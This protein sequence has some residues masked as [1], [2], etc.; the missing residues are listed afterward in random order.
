MK[1]LFI[2][3]TC[4]RFV[5]HWL[6]FKQ[7]KNHEIIADDLAR[8]IAQF[9]L[10]K[11]MVNPNKKDISFYRFC[12]LLSFYKMVRNIFYARVKTHSKFAVKVMSLFA[13]PQS[14]LDISSSASIGGGLIVQHG[15]A[16]IIDPRSMGQNCW[17]NQGVT[18]GYTNDTDC[19]T[20]GNNV[21]IGAG[22][23]VLGNVTVG[24]NVVIGANCVVV[25]D[26]PS[27]STV[28]GV[29]ARIVKMN[30]VKVDIKL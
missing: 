1:R 13:F 23:K 2:Y 3:L 19:P 9:V 8:N 30:G 29:P 16:T 18:I 22:A 7:A 15:Y 12:Y 27:N 14:F 17:V 25:K 4:F 21:V 6:Y 11:G 28:V 20:I 26:I 10:R 24:D 5:I